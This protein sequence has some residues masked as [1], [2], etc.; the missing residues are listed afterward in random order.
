MKS[1]ID[2]GAGIVRLS[3]VLAHASGEWIA[4]DWPVCAISETATPHRM[5]AALTYA[6]R[7]ALFNLVRTI[8]MRLISWRRQLQLPAHKQGSDLMPSTKA[9]TSMAVKHIQRGISQVGGAPRQSQ[10]LPRQQALRLM[11]R[12]LCATN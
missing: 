1:P 10:V 7:Y 12:P 4:S 8:L 2:E 5:G 6:R 9:A 3:T 11:P